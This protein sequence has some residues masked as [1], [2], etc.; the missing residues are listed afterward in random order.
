MSGASREA[1]YA[2]PPR[3]GASRSRAEVA[4]H[5]R[6]FRLTADSESA[7][8]ARG[9][10]RH[11]CSSILA[12]TRGRCCAA[13]SVVVFATSAVVIVGGGRVSRWSSWSLWL[14]FSSPAEP[15]VSSAFSLAP[16]LGWM[17][18]VV[19]SSP[20]HAG[21]PIPAPIPNAAVATMIAARFILG[22][23]ARLEFVRTPESVGTSRPIRSATTRPRVRRLPPATGGQAALVAGHRRA[24]IVAWRRAPTRG[25]LASR[26]MADYEEERVSVAR[27]PDGY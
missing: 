14:P 9:T 3:P 17:T 12:A 4:I 22:P 27:H 15:L 20:P 5:Q 13:A 6:L 18:V 24:S 25:Q 8:D 16:P 1:P 2:L 19:V 7:P 21:I 23:F 10:P 11:C 26:R